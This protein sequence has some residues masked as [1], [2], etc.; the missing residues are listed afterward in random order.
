MKKIN[1]IDWFTTY[2]QKKGF[3]VGGNIIIDFIS[4]ET[5]TETIRFFKGEN[6]KYLVVYILEFDNKKKSSLDYKNIIK[7][8]VNKLSIHNE[9]TLIIWPKEEINKFAI[10]K[11]EEFI[12]N[13]NTHNVLSFF[14]EFD[15]SLVG[16]SSYIKRINKGYTDFFHKW[17]REYLK[18]FQ[19]DID[20]FLN[21]NNT[22]H[23]LELKRPQELVTTWRPYKAD[24]NNYYEFKLFCDEKN[25]QLTN[26][27]YSQRQK[28]KIKVFKNVTQTHRGLNYTQST[29]EI[30]PMDD[31]IQLVNSSSFNEEYSTR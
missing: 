14:S 5:I 9:F 13:L 17:A 16:K 4:N 12:A 29:L 21:L 19:N 25:Y 10:Y 23:M 11:N 20:S 28:W 26:I 15:E 27:A 2:L 7:P 22:L 18:G 8:I 31:L 24:A 30:S 1:K 3:W 6:E